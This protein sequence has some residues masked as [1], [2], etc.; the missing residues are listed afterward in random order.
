MSDLRLKLLKL[1]HENKG[2]Y[3]SGSK[4]STE[5][6]VSRTAIWKHI[7]ELKIKGYDIDSRSNRGYSLISV[8]NKIVPEE[9]LL[10]LKTDYIGQEI[11][12]FEEID[13]TNKK[14]KMLAVKDAK[15]GTVVIAERQNGGKGRLDREWYSP[16]NSGLWFS[17]ILRPD[18]KPDKAPL[19]TVTASLAVVV[20]LER[21]G[22]EVEIKWPNDILINGKKVCGILSEMSAD[23]DK[24]NYAIVGI[25]I[26]VNQKEFPDYLREI[27][28]SIRMN[29]GKKIDRN[30][31]LQKILLSFTGYYNMLL[32]DENE[33][34]IDIWQQRLNI[35]NQNIEISSKGKLHKGKAVGVSKKGELLVKEKDRIISFWAGDATFVKGKN[36]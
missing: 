9:I 16:P 35:V 33:R 3:I 34:I 2:Q 15:R 31:L 17:L 11:S 1:L 21:Y 24:I 7:K 32:K 29:I 26:N 22:L 23:M 30:K 18:F 27:A 25:G 13:S 8:T 4:M 20:V 5:L 6:G 12:F 19:L 36:K 14:A 10:G 28:T